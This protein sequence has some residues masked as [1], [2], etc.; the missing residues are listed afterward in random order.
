M[1][2]FKKSLEGMS[3]NNELTYLVTLKYAKS[4]LSESY[5]FHLVRIFVAFIQVIRG[6]FPREQ[7]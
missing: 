1:C 4:F 5:G 3:V 2:S 6:H 7:Y